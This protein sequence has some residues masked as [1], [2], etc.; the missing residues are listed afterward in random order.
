MRTVSYRLVD[1]QKCMIPLGFVGENEHTVVQFDCK[2]VYDEYP[3]AVPAL[4]VQPPEGSAYPA[5]TTRDGDIVSWTVED[6]DLVYTGYGEFQLTFSQ[7]GVV[8][9][10]YI[11]RTKIER[12]IAASGSAPDPVSDWLTE[13][14][15]ALNGIPQAIDDALA[16]AKASGEFD[17]A[18]GQDGADGF[19]PVV[20]VSEISGGH[21][22]SV[23][24]AGG[25]ETFDVMNGED[26]Q[27]GAPGADGKDGKDGKDGTDGQDG[28]D[29]V[30]PTVAITTITGG[31]R[32]TITDATGDHSYDVMDGDP[33]AIIDDT[34]GAG[35]T[36]K[37]F[38]A[39]KLT[40]EL[41]GVKS[42]INSMEESIAPVEASA[43]ATAAHAVGELF[44]L[45]DSLLV[46][47]SAIAVGDTITTT[48][49][50]PN[51]AVT[52]LS[53]KLI[54]DVQVNGSS[55][56]SSGVANV[57]AASNSALGVVKG[58]ASGVYG[59]SVW[60]GAT[61]GTLAIEPASD[62]DIKNGSQSYKP[63]APA[64]EQNAAFYGLAKAAGDTSQSS[65]SNAV[66][67]YTEDAKLKI[68]QM[69]GLWEPKCYVKYT[70][71]E[72][73]NNTETMSF[74]QLNV[75]IEIY[76]ELVIVI[77]QSDSNNGQTI[78]SNDW[79][80]LNVRDSVNSVYLTS[81]SAGYMKGAKPAILKFKRYPYCVICEVTSG[82]ASLATY[83]YPRSSDYL[84]KVNFLQLGS[85]SG[86]IK[87]GTT[88]EAFIHRFI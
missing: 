8:V 38:S 76:E 43:T 88:I 85:S 40:T 44:I 69:L 6:S 9:K 16:E 33:A 3:N 20:E 53:A 67:V 29:G 86:L 70:Q 82:G 4:T 54:K 32:V 22:V 11:G 84:D 87:A 18:D 68:Q 10:S 48:G 60:S 25:T 74:D 49:A 41:N 30:S 15:T 57:S 75:P 23:T 19:S 7:S 47:L 42:A 51:A 55:V 26:G 45:D 27:D 56:L 78:S 83:A 65:S 34:A 24:D 64:K 13:A 73:A 5:V 12:S 39:D 63:I 71:E 2:K 52:T 36:G 66:G 72:D 59:V 61:A 80:Y 37:T 50:T 1:L 58:S 14:N 62:S 21:R 17:G 31:H 81:N 35:D 79:N 28:T 77:Y 46:A